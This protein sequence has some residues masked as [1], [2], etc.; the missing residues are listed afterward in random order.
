MCHLFFFTISP[1]SELTQFLCLYL[2]F[3]ISAGINL[4]SSPLFFNF[5]LGFFTHLLPLTLFLLPRT[6]SLR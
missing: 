5:I 2:N 3:E 1:N 4:G 6:Q